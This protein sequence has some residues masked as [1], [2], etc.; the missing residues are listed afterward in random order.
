MEN[1]GVEA[2]TVQEAQAV[3]ELVNLVEDSSANLDDGELGRV[4]GV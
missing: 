1:D 3:S 4:G 2:D